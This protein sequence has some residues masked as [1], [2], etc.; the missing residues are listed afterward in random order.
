MA[1]RSDIGNGDTC[2][3][4]PEHGNMFTL[5]DSDPPLQRCAHQAHDGEPGPSGAPASR[6]V[7]PLY[8]FEESV[9]TYLA[10]LDRAI[11]LSGEVA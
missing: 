10:R 7:W 8:G 6:S 9:V 4:F 2:P 1:R 3:L 11:R 5:K